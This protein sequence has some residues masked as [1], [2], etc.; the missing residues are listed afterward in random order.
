MKRNRVVLAW[1]VAVL[2]G[3]PGRLPAQEE[4]AQR[5]EDVEALKRQLEAQEATIED[6]KRKLDELD[7]TKPVVPETG[8]DAVTEE[9]AD[10]GAAPSP[11]EDL[12]RQWRKIDD[13]PSQV[14]YRDQFN[15]RQG[16]AARPE[17]FALDP[18]YRGFTQ[19]GDTVFMLRFNPRPRVD[20]T[21]DTQNTGNDYRFVTGQIPVEG[22]PERGGGMEFNM[23]GNG[24]QL[25]VDIRAPSLDGDFRLYYQNDFF[26]S[27]T[28]AFRY[29]MQH[30]YGQYYGVL[31][32]YTFGVFEDPDAWPDT[33]DYE[34]PNSVIFARRVVL[35][36]TRALSD[37]V[38]L[39][40]GVEDP[41]IFLDETYPDPAD[42]TATISAGE[43][44]TRMPDTGFNVRWED[45]DYGHLQFSSIFRT[46]GID[47]DSGV[48]ATTPVDDDD[49]FGWGIN[50]SGSLELTERDRLLFW[51]VYGHGVGGM[52]NDT[53]FFDSDAA[54]D[55]DGDLKALEYVSGMLG[56]THYWSQRLRSTA[57]YGYVN[58]GNS[59]AQLDSAFDKSQ[60]ASC[61]IIYQL[62]KRLSVG[63]ET[64]YGYKKEKDG[65]SGQVVRFQ[66]GLVY[67]MF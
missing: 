66:I 56:Y 48:S 23:N 47:V 13:R 4:G 15:D 49:V 27:D 11:A 17:D 12:E 19:I 33:V 62:Y 24:S 37:H 38:N 51:G 32:G 8:D 59:G 36:Y 21:L 53:S 9:P 50:L 41:D 7:L 28:S 44:R 22:D 20:L 64:L 42:P 58:I 39:T 54:L 16:P 67:S 40:V 14:D 10:D 65:D 1:L 18:A 52:G 43:L 25:R 34:G 46:I 5:D 31:G 45:S 55:T 60:Y 29:R 26:G 57:T 30:F 2:V 3:G 63:F 6:M 61:N 35:H